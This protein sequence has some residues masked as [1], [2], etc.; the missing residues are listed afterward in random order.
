MSEINIERVLQLEQEFH[1]A[2]DTTI[3]LL[4]E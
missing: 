4:L 1:T 3:S 2:K